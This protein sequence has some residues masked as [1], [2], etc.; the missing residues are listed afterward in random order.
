MPN[1]LFLDALYSCSNIPDV[2]D[3]YSSALRNSSIKGADSHANLL[4]LYKSYITNK[5]ILDECRDNFTYAYNLI[6][7]KLPNVLFEITGR[8]KSL[9]SVEKKIRTVEDNA[10]S[11][12]S[13]R[14]F[15]AFRICLL[16]NGFK[17]IEDCYK[18]TNLII[19]PFE[20]HGCVLCD[21]D[22]FP[23]SHDDFVAKNKELLDSKKII[24]PS[25]PLFNSRYSYGIKDYVFNPKPNGYQ[26]IHLTFRNSHGKC[27][28][29][30]IRTLAM[31]IVADNGIA[32][33]SKYKS[34]NY[35]EIA[36]DYK[37]VNIEGFALDEESGKLY[38]KIGLCQQLPI[39]GRYKTF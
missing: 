35:Q 27:F 10:K 37:K 31:H 21:S 12:D 13:I 30:Q 9:I 38:D 7:Q 24:I 33:H 14:D 2:L 4:Q 11:L 5:Q 23:S 36:F 28:E 6:S 17:S 25:E 39:L 32:A 34:N 26:S 22:K 16:N 29:V 15:F 18:V 1:K 19:A 8:R 20:S 3:S